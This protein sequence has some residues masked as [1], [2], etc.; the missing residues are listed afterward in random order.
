MK[1]TKSLLK[2]IIK[3]ETGKIN[4]KYNLVEYGGGHAE[5]LQDILDRYKHLVM[6]IQ[7]VLDQE[8]SGQVNSDGALIEIQSLI[9]EEGGSRRFATSSD[10][11]NMGG[12]IAEEADNEKQ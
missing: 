1:L 6:D 5:E 11:G 2:Q 3:E 12:A 9:D 4:K 10:V 7:G 8:A